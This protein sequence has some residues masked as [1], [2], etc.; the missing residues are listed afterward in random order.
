MHEAFH[1][2][3]FD[4]FLLSLENHVSFFCDEFRNMTRKMTR[5]FRD[6]T[7]FT[8]TMTITIFHHGQ[9][10]VVLVNETSLTKSGYCEGI[11]EISAI[12]F[13]V[14]WLVDSKCEVLLLKIT[15]TP[16]GR[17]LAIAVSI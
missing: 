7:N 6:M 4:F 9:D 17:A 8:I 15:P 14:F 5:H 13:E 10:S 3:S 11:T 16:I 12:I 2:N 1:K